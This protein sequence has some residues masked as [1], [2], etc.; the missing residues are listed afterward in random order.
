MGNNKGKGKAATP[1]PASAPAA[2]ASA[3]SSSKK[4]AKSSAA[5]QKKPAEDDFIVFTNSTK[6]KPKNKKAGVADEQAEPG[7]PGPPKPTVKQIIGGASWTGKL[8][9]NLLSEHCQKQKWNR[10]DYQPVSNCL[11]SGDTMYMVRKNT[12]IDTYHRSV[13]PRA[14]R[15]LSRSALRTTRRTRQSS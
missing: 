2:G 6:D 9:V 10:P 8:P 3:N 15:T 7:P 11:S 4:S 12:S 13:G 1:A 14:S 5:A